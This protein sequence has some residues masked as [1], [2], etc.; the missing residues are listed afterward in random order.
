MKARLYMFTSPFRSDNCWQ[1]ATCIVSPTSSK[2]VA[3]LLAVLQA[4]NAM[5]SVRSGGHDFNVNHSSIGSTGLLMDMVNFNNISLSADKSTVKVGAGAHW[6]DVYTFLNGTGVSVNGA[7]SPNP[8]VVGSTIGGGMGWFS[9]LAGPTAASLVGAQVVLANG[10][11]VDVDET[12]GA[13]LL[14]GLR[15][16]GPNF[17]VVTSLTYRTLPIDKIWY[18]SNLYTRDKNQQLLN[19]LVAYQQQTSDDNATIVYQL[20]VDNTTADSFVGFIYADATSEWP[21]VFAPFYA[22]E[23]AS[24]LINSTV[25]TIADLALEYNSPQYP[26]PGTSRTRHYV[27]SL[28]HA[29]NNATYQESYE[30]FVPLAEQAASKGW[31][32]EYGA[33]LMSASGAEAASD[34]PLNLSLV[35]QDWVHVTMAWSSPADDADAMETIHQIGQAIADAAVRHNSTL[36]YRFMN[37]ANSNQRVL[38]SYGTGM[39]RRLREI[40]HAYDPDRMF[41]KQ[42]QSGWLLSL[43]GLD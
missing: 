16:G 6:G 25:G 43:E 3:Q 29:V 41:Q 19:A 33:Q 8:G 31:S 39:A 1:N 35:S 4:T 20:S 38:S 26:D 17:G 14:W 2:D 40:S 27:V 7:K 11:V 15:G 5:F 34:T 28:P 24:A 12:L 13:D 9:T 22:V 36:S 18:A 42:Q 21:L 23:A 10:S 30:A 37:D 32:M